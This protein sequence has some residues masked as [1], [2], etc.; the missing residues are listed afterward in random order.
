MYDW[1]K[2]AY[3]VVLNP[4]ES[5]LV[6][7]KEVNEILLEYG[8]YRIKNVIICVIKTNNKVYFLKKKYLN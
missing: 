5:L 3:N 6:R 2:N 7:P 4:N 1:L 8:N